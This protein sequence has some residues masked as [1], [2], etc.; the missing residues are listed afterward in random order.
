MSGMER[1]SATFLLRWHC[2]M[3]L[4][5]SVSQIKHP[6]L[7]TAGHDLCRPLKASRQII[8]FHGGIFSFCFVFFSG[9]TFLASTLQKQ[10]QQS[11]FLVALFS[12]PG[13][14]T[15]D[16]VSTWGWSMLSESF[17]LPLFKS[18]CF[19]ILF[20]WIHLWLLRRTK[21][22]LI[23]SLLL[24]NFFFL[25]RHDLIKSLAQLPSKLFFN[26]F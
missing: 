7:Y 23:L 19:Q 18:Y 21:T 20:Y 5:D 10:F 17:D 25:L 22:R 3:A 9:L 1:M 2:P 24:G 8:P 15:R 14:G 16:I 26:F 4:A 13:R 12:L 11:W 6:R